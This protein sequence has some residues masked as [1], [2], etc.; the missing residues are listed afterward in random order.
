MIIWFQQ[1][2]INVLLTLLCHCPSSHRHIQKRFPGLAH[3][4]WDRNGAA[5][6]AEKLPLEMLHRYRRA[7]LT[8]RQRLV[9][10]ASGEQRKSEVFMVLVNVSRHWITT[11]TVG[12]PREQAAF[13]DGPV[14]KGT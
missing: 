11:A 8:S 14:T 10:E 7:L 9:D 2:R 6:P 4:V 3:I 13:H 12:K 1:C 5:V